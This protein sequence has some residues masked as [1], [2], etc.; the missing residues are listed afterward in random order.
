ML[1]HYQPQEIVMLRNSTLLAIA[2]SATAIVSVT[3]PAAA[4][5]SQVFGGGGNSRIVAEIHPAATSMQPSRNAN[6]PKIGVDLPAK[7]PTAAPV[8]GWKVNPP[9]PAAP[10]YTGLG[11]DGKLIPAVQ[12][13]IPAGAASSGLK[14]PQ[15]PDKNKTD[16]CAGAPQDLCGRLPPPAPPTGGSGGGGGSGGSS[17]GSGGSGGSTGGSGGS[18]AGNSGKSGGGT[19]VILAPSVQVPVPYG[20]AS[21][22]TSAPSYAAAQTRP[23][24]ASQP[25]TPQCGAAGSIPALAA[26]IDQLLPTAQLSEADM[27]KVTELRQMIQVLSTDG[28]A[29]AARDVEEIAMNILGYQKVWL[30]CGLGTFDWEKQVASADA[31]QQK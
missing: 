8:S 5:P 23:A 4:N 25:I 15:I 22:I 1:N 13:K 27:G 26:G 20:V 31:V 30:R 16:P 17:G 6:R 18:S 2:L 7:I 28:K 10:V 24:V 11:P 14:T 29:A 9:K 21:R 12:P 3:V 19:V